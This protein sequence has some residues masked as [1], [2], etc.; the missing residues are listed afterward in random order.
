MRPS[1]SKDFIVV[2]RTA[3][4]TL[5]IPNHG[6][7][8]HL[9]GTGRRLQAKRKRIPGTADSRNQIAIPEERI[10]STC[11]RAAQTNRYTA[12]ASAVGAAAC[13]VENSRIRVDRNQNRTRGRTAIGIGHRDLIR[14]CARNRDFS[15]RFRGAP[16]I[17]GAAAG[18]QQ[19]RRAGAQNT[20]V[21]NAGG[22]CNSNRRRRQRI[23]G[24]LVGAT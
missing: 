14:T 1:F 2:L 3:H 8:D 17:G 23:Y 7:G 19:G 4:E 22:F 20:V 18:R 12:A 13:H 10:I 6:I 5:A 21:G 24:Y 11:F 16:Q 9:I 15:S